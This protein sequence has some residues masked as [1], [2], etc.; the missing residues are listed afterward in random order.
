MNDLFIG[1]LAVAVVFI[2]FNYGFNHDDR[3]HP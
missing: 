2:G 1:L 3:N